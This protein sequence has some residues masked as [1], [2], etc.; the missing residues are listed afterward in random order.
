MGEYKKTVNEVIVV[1]NRELDSKEWE[2]QIK[3]ISSQ[4]SIIWNDH[5]KRGKFYS[6]QLGAKNIKTEYSFIQNVDNPFINSFL[7]EEILKEKNPN[8]ITIPFRGEQGGHPVLIS[9][10]V[11]RSISILEGE[12]IHLRDFFSMFSKK[13]AAVQDD[14]IFVNINTPEDYQNFLLVK[15]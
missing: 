1:M 4:C 8:G 15:E 5:G 12:G 9:A 11:L 7:L 10:N 3:K 14:S 2:S 13:F 6:L